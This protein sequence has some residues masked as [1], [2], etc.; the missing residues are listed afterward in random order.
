MGFLEPVFH[1]ALFFSK[2]GIFRVRKRQERISLSVF[3]DVPVSLFFNNFPQP[4][5]NLSMDSVTMP[6][7][8]VKNT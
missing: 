6:T 2:T 8:C 1:G 3:K 5:N 4:Q 7:Y